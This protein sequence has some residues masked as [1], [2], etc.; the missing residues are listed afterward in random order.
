M[1][2]NQNRLQFQIS[3]KDGRKEL[4]VEQLNPTISFQEIREKVT[5]ERERRRAMD[6]L[7]QISAIRSMEGED[8]WFDFGKL[9]KGLKPVAVMG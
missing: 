6:E 8:D 1:R 4:T 3:F 7:K 5:V 9:F 2:F